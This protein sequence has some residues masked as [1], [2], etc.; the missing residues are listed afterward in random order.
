[1][2]ERINW[3]S[4]VWTILAISESQSLRQDGLVYC[5]SYSLSLGRFL[6][7]PIALI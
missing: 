7:V 2:G 3:N 4:Q 1:V 5:D 6:D